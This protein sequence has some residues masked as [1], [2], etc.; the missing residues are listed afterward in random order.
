[1]TEI[2]EH[3]LGP[4][5]RRA[6]RPPAWPTP[7]PRRGATAGH[8]DGAAARSPPVAPAAAAATPATPPP[9][10]RRPPPP[11]PEP[12][13]VEAVKDRKKIPFWAMPV[14]VAAAALGVH[15][16][17]HARDAAAAD[18]PARWPTGR[19][20]YAELR[21][22]P[23][24]RRRGRRRPGVP[25]RRARASTLPELQ[26]PDQL[27]LA[28]ARPAGPGDHLRRAE[29]ADDSGGM[30]AWAGT[31]AHRRCEIA[32]VVRYEREVARR[33]S[34]PEPD[35]VAITE[36]TKRRRST[37]DGNPVDAASQRRDRTPPTSSSSAAGPPAR[38]PR[39]GWPGR[40]RRRRR[41]A[42][43][44]PPREDLRRRAHAAGGAPARG[45]GPRRRR[46]TQFHRYDG[47][48]AIAHGITLELQ[49]PEHPCSRATATSCGAATSTSSSPTTPVA[50]GA[51]LRQGTEAIAP[52][53]RRR[54]RRAAR[55]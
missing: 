6:A 50:A 23:R 8:A 52:I 17:Q 49:W 13:Y 16:R 37:T 1:M 10:R 32:E 26:G 31:A 14:L 15:L 54:A 41:R 34:P 39:T 51:T 7:S 43:D 35:L 25:E 12:P 28:R 22:L 24:R 47:L 48:R 36:G 30:P 55:S 9:L 38:P 11:K 46:S 53:A 33:R 2:P 18:E 29:Q 44:V 19:T 4:V 5:A 27:G 40:P 20:I 45:H 42:Q 3:L 21:Q